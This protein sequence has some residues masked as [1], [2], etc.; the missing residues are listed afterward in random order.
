MIELMAMRRNLAS[1]AED[2]AASVRDTIAAARDHAARLRNLP[3]GKDRRICES[4][5]S[6]MVAVFRAAYEASD[7]FLRFHQKRDANGV[8]MIYGLSIQ[9]D[10]YTKTCL[11]V[12]VDPAHLRTTW[13]LHEG[14][15]LE[16]ALGGWWTIPLLQMEDQDALLETKVL[17]LIR[18]LRETPDSC[19]SR[20]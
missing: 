13:Q 20:Y 10:A 1:M 8:A 17:D 9:R 2:F 5:A 18:T 19:R 14:G 6:R 3:E 15:N 4:L 7:G 12:R 11:F 16:H